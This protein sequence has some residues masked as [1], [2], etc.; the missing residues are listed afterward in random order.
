M[1]VESVC[2]GCGGQFRQPEKEAGMYCG[3]EGNR[4]IGPWCS[5]RC[6]LGSIRKVGPVLLDMEFGRIRNNV[7]N[8][9]EA[10]VWKYLWKMLEEGEEVVR[11]PG[12]LRLPG[13]RRYCPDFIVRPYNVVVEVKGQWGMRCGTKEK[14]GRVLAV[15]PDNRFVLVTGTV[16]KK[17]EREMTR[18]VG[19]RAGTT[20]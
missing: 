8:S 12:Y 16:V 14:F 3:L 4:R 19:K 18:K 10:I 2:V 15:Y 13:G 7:V 1:L 5:P 6:L 9:W 17:M 11:E 20:G